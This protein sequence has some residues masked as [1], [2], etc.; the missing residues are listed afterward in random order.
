MHR[1]VNYG[2]FLQAYGLKRLIGDQTNCSVVF[3]DYQYE[4]SLVEDDYIYE[5]IIEKLK[6]NRSF[7]IIG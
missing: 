4:K 2:S 6:K 7:Q 1:I 3:I 5:T